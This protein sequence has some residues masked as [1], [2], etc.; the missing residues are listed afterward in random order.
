MN[1][2]NTPTDQLASAPISDPPSQEIRIGS[3]LEALWLY[4]VQVETSETGRSVGELLDINPLLP[5]IIIVE[6]GNFLGM[7]SRAVFRDYLGRPFGRSLFLK[8]SILALHQIANQD[9]LI[10][11]R[12]T[13]IVEAVGLALMRSPKD[14]YEPVVVRLSAE[15]Y[16][17][18]D[19]HQL[20][21]AQ[22][23]IQKLSTELIRQ[24]TQQ[25][26]IQTEKMASLGQMVAGIS[27]EIRNPVNTILGNLRYLDNYCQSLMQ[28]VHAYGKEYPQDAPPI[29]EFKEEIEL[30]FIF[31]DVPGLLQS[32]GIAS[33]RVQE[34]ANGLRTFSRVGESKKKDINVHECIDNTL[35]LIKSRTKQGIEVVKNYGDVPPVLCYSG[36]LSQVFMNIMN[37]AI[38]ALEEK[39]AREKAKGS[40]WTTPRLTI[41][42]S[43][44]NPQ[45]LS[46]KIADNA[47]GIPPE[48]QDK[49]FEMFFTTKSAE[50][51]TGL[52]LAISHQIITEKHGGKLLLSSEVDRGTEFEVI[53]PLEIAT[54]D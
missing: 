3:T 44:P 4:K 8:R 32:V 13:P 48:I 33:E 1:T 52:G 29:K 39:K 7:I 50:T 54:T 36:Q 53:L 35:L 10:L 26:L 47:D 11:P 14:L 43:V 25:Q 6:N 9:M 20:L 18:V 45:E 41:T 37:N 2:V 21:V 30:D 49:I 23:Q 22:S 46:I 19:V 28:M 15:D 40:P 12:D 16:R 24:Q 31:E 42:T 17:L 5:G 38:D 34:L 27:H 51:G